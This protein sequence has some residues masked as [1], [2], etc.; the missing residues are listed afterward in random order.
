[1]KIRTI[2]LLMPAF[3]A[4]A[5]SAAAQEKSSSTT[6]KSVTGC[7]SGPNSEGA[8]VLKPSKGRAFEVGGNDQLKSHVGHTVKLTGTWAKSGAEIGENEANEKVE[9]HETGEKN[10]AEH[11]EVAE[12]HFK[13]ADI[14]HI[15]DT[16]SQP[17]SEDQTAIPL[18]ICGSVSYSRALCERGAHGPFDFA[19][20]KL[21][22][23][24]IQ[25]S[26]VGFSP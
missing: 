14:Q 20:G 18:T 12:T 10:E 5:L 6:Q 25:R 3:L 17:R 4:L 19:Q 8:F 22:A 13:V 9:K 2:S 1:M 7:L 11:R 26:T 24:P 23:V 15:S 16:C 21:S